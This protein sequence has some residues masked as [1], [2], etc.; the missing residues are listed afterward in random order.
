MPLELAGLVEQ[1]F[2]RAR[3]QLGSGAWSTAVV[4]LLEEALGEELRAEGF[5][6]T[7]GPG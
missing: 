2:I 6:A 5:P 4:K 3:Q 7:L 1:T